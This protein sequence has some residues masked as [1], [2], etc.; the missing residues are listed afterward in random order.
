[1]VLG[2][3]ELAPHTTFSTSANPAFQSSALGGRWVVFAAAPDAETE[4]GLMAQLNSLG[5]RL[6]G[7]D[8]L[9]FAILRDP[10]AA[11]ADRM[12]TPGLRFVFD[13][14]GETANVFD[15]AGGGWLLLDPMLRV[16][17]VA[18]LADGE[19]FLRQ[20]CAL[21]DPSRHAGADIV[22]PILLAPRIFEPEICRRLIALYRDDGG[23]PS[24][25]MRDINGRTVPVLDDFKKRRD[26]FVTDEAFQNQLRIRI[27]R[28]LVPEIER[29]LQFT[30]T[31][32]E[33]YIVACYDA[34]SGGYFRPH[35]DNT[36]KG[37]A[38]RKFA[39]TINLNDDFEGGELRFPEFGPQTYRPPAG[40][41]VVF[42]CSMLHEAT[43]VTRG[44]R[45]A[46]LPFL[47]DEEGA[48]IRQENMKYL[49]S[50][51]QAEASA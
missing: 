46:F 12:Q 21:P 45:Y 32:I 3:G 47:F 42:S 38:H 41:A 48:R 33:R 24:G 44:V 10:A 23:A 2:I 25:V 16:H 11:H 31:R 34:E 43:P 6:D 22:A 49:D 26:A 7:W 35:R 36:T 20:V 40:G 9:A 51:D 19:S 4:A 37:T 5:A 14:R 27:A 8:T 1:M 15:L 17:A 39:V 30:V 13:P 28:R 18:S 50:A 29:V